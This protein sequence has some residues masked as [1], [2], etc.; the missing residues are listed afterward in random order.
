MEHAI[1]AALNP[2]SGRLRGYYDDDS[3]CIGLTA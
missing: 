3:L 1:S 2:V